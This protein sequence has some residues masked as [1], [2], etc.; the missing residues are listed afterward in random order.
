MIHSFIHSFHPVN[1]I[2]NP[3]CMQRM[4]TRDGFSEAEARARI[5]AQMPV[6]EKLAL[7]DATLWNNGT[8]VAAIN[9]RSH[10]LAADLKR[11]YSGLSLLLSGPGVAVVALAAAASAW[12]LLPWWL[13]SKS[14]D[15]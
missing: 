6:A 13:L 8:V 3:T 4:A 10:E 11:R 9:G 2:F 12:T 5:N 14:I 7:A 15:R 1:A